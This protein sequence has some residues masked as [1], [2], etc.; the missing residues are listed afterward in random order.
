MAGKI[1]WFEIPV[2]DPQRAMSF[3]G[4]LMGWSFQKWDEFAQDY[5]LIEPSQEI[6]VGGGMLTPRDGAAPG[7]G[8]V[9]YFEVPSLATATADA[10]RLGGSVVQEPREI[11]AEAGWSA[12]LQD[13]EGNRLGVWA[14]TS[15]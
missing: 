5:W 2:S 8:P 12:I 1:V 10:V 7:P 14:P 9:A 6:G 11:S 4:E 15:G 13:T 3:Y